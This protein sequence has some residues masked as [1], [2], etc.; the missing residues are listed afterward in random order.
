[1]S[2]VLKSLGYSIGRKR[3]QRLM[4]I[5]G[6][7]AMY[8]KPKLSIPGNQ[9]LKYPYRLIGLPITGPNHAWGIDISLPQQ[10]A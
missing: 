2:M 1:M 5:M 3:A 4:R 6:L 8:E 7:E 10:A 9:S